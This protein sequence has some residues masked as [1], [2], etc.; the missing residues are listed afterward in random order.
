MDFIWILIAFGC[1]LGIKMTG[2]PPLIGYLLAGFILNFIG[3]EHQDGLQTLSDL[4]ITLMLFTIGL[5]VKISDLL[6]RETLIG[7]LSHM[8][9]WIPLCAATLLGLGALSLSYLDVISLQTALLLSFAFSFSS[10]VCIVKLL[11][12]SGELK[13]RHGKLAIGILVIQDIVA[14]VFL[15]TTTGK[16]PSIMALALFGLLLIRPLANKLLNQVGHNELLPLTGICLALGGYE[17]FEAVNIKGDLGALIFGMLLSHHP[18]AVEL[19]KSLMN[20]RDLFLISFFLSIGFVAL[21]TLS[22]IGVSLLLCLLLPLKYLLFFFIFAGTGLRGRTSYLSALAL[23]NYSEFGLIVAA[24]SVSS[25][26]LNEEWLV[27]LAL[28]ASFS[29]VITSLFHRYAHRIYSS[30]KDLF[31]HYERAKRLPGDRLSQPKEAEILVI[32]LGRVGK[33]AY[34]ALANVDQN[35]VWGMDADRERVYRLKK[36]GLQVFFGDAE[37]ADFWDS[38]ELNNIKLVL[39]ALPSIKDCCNIYDQLHAAHYHGKT[40]A[41]ARFEDE[42][43]QLLNKGFDKVFNFYTEAGTGFADESLQMLSKA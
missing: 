22:M 37:D 41:I 25:G 36:S 29:F 19:N 3:I 12:E 31:K 9:I 40:A 38:I 14:V 10:T 5:K 18:K 43:Q 30:N 23:S 16:A 33:G 39:F 24:L 2:L 11:E 32:G 21:P 1:G 15:A 28:S 6:Q 35:R 8:L 4:G 34:Q 26:W 13:T 20:F 17:V 7:S 27:I 42:Q